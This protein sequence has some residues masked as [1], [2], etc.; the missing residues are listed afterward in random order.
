MS[1]DSTVWFPYALA[2]LWGVISV[3]ISLEGLKK[4]GA[5]KLELGVVFQA[6]FIAFINT[7]VLGSAVVGANLVVGGMTSTVG[8]PSSHHL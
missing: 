4:D 3:L 1:L 6:I 5:S 8:A 2:F 7:M